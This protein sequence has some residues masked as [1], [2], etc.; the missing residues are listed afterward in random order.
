MSDRLFW[1]LARGVAFL[2]AGLVILAINVPW[3]FQFPP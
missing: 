2:L 3:T 1:P